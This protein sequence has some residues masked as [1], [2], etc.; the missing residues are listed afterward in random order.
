[1]KYKLIDKPIVNHSD[2]EELREV[3]N[4]IV[5]FSENGIEEFHIDAITFIPE[6]QM[7]TFGIYNCEKSIEGEVVYADYEIAVVDTD[8]GNINAYIEDYDNNGNSYLDLP[9]DL[10]QLLSTWSSLF[11]HQT[12]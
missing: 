10:S 2:V 12:L 4:L 3:E 11:Q 1:M 7:V 5:K 8:N 6:A 9:K